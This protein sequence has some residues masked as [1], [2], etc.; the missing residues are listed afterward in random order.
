MVNSV[1]CS[2]RRRDDKK[3][4]IDPFFFSRENAL[5]FGVVPPQLPEL[6]QTEEMLIA[7]VHVHVQV[8]QYRGQQYKYR[9]HV[10]NFLRDTGSVYSQLPLLPSDLDII[11]L[12]PRNTTN[13]PHMLRQFRSQFRVRQRHI[14]TW[15]R[16]LR[17]HHPGYR[18]IAVDEDRLSQL[19]EDANIT[20]QLLTENVE[21]VN[22]EDNVADEDL[23]DA[24][25]Y[26]GAA[27]PNFIAA[28]ADLEQL[29]CQL[30]GHLAQNPE[31]VP[32]RPYLEMPAIRSTPISE[33]NR[34]QPLLSLAFPTLYPNGEA[35]FITPRQRTIKYNEYIEHAMKWHDGRFARHPR[36]RYV[37]F[38]TLMRQQVNQR[39]SFFVRRSGAG[40]RQPVDANELREAFNDDTPESR[41]L[42]NSI[43]R[44]SG[45][46]RGTRAFWNGRR[47]QL[48][49]YVHG[50]GCPGT[51]LTFSAADLHWD[52]LQRLMP[53]YHEWQQADHRSRMTIARVNLRDNP[54]IAAYHFHV[55]YTSFLEKVLKPKFNIDDYWYRYEWQARGSTHAHGLFWVK[56]SPPTPLETPEAIQ[57]FINFWTDFA[58]AFNPEPQRPVP[59]G[60]TDPLVSVSE[61]PSFQLLSDIVNRVQNHR[62]TEAYCLRRRRLNNGQ[63]SEERFCR[64]Y[65]PRFLHDEAIVTQRFNPQHQIYDGERNDPN[66]NNYNRLIALAWLANHDFSP[67]T[68]LW[69][70]LAYLAKYTAKAETKTQSYKAVVEEILPRLGSNRP[71]V[72][73]VARFMNKLASER[74]W[75]AME[76]CHLLLNLP[77]Q[78]GSR[79][80]RTVDCR[81]V[82]RQQ[83]RSTMIEDDG[84]VR[85]TRSAY[86][87]YL[88]RDVEWEGLTYFAF[89]TTIDYSRQAWRPFP[90]AKPRVLNYFPRYKPD[91]DSMDYE[92]FCRVK[93]LLHHPHRDPN[94]LKTVED[95]VFDTFTE[96][97]DYCRLVH[98]GA[99][100]HDYYGDLPLPPAAD[101]EEE[102]HNED[103]IAAEDW[104]ELAQQLPQRELDTE[105]IDILGNRDLDLRH[106]WSGHIGRY[107][108][109]LEVGREYWNKAK[110]E[111]TADD[112]LEV[113]DSV[114]DSLN[115]EQRLVF[116][117]FSRH[118][119][120]MLDPTVPNPPQLLLQVDG[121]GGTGKSFMIHAITSRLQQ[122]SPGESI[123]AKAAPTGVAANA[124]NGVTLHSLLRLPISKNLT[125]LPPLTPTEL[126]NLQAKL[127]AIR[128][129]IIDEKSM[130]GLRMLSYIDSRLRQI[131][132]SHQ[133]QFFGGRSIMLLGDFYQLPPVMEKPLYMDENLKS[134]LD[135][136]GRNAYLQ[137]NKTVVLRQVVRQQ[138][139]DQAAFRLALKGLRNNKPEV[140]HWRQL[141]SRLQS[142]LSFQEVS[143][144]D[145]A[146][147]IYP[148]NAQVKEY[149]LEHIDRLQL[150]CIQ[151]AATNVGP[152]AEE[153]D[154]T[155]AG[156]LHNKL[157][158]CIGTRVML[159]E[160]LWTATGLVNGALGSVFDISWRAD[161]TDPRKEHP[162]VILVKLDKY[163]GPAFFED[164]HLSTVVPIF[165]SNR[166]FIKVNTSC[167]R[168]QFALTVAYSITVHKS[169]GM[170]LERAVAD[171][172]QR[173]FQHGLSYVA[174]SRV[175]RLDGI[176]FDAAFDLPAI[177]TQAD[178]GI[179]ARIR[180]KD[181]RESQT[182]FPR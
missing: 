105:D 156:N 30:D 114:F 36:F 6:S 123:V 93:L 44:Y 29:R 129:I 4:P 77:L 108:E 157:P 86:D 1:C 50:L 34:S 60:D 75:S 113:P 140:N 152:K 9:G 115:A 38:N 133:D 163:T 21:E 18:D 63:L 178:G 166:D 5:H 16:Y 53:R 179:R 83:S 131:F 101:F 71:L 84:T 162:Y 146:V 91:R 37:V 118:L 103:N 143:S 102:P 120:E 145:D 180:D 181:R 26:D 81:P 64:F 122:L 88:H 150:P 87:K 58:I 54:H 43:V 151:V 76:I 90:H 56:D 66:L 35:D 67:C 175:K 96:A 11:I 2:C 132:P 136:K 148:T 14:R 80:T 33:F 173:D 128:Y 116:D 158:L 23:P 176:M 39:S 170:T 130:I 41:A 168:T 139:D 125:E 100:E 104:T 174:V 3:G 55:R 24:D 153:A 126:S 72:S 141:C 161:V 159:T 172:S 160:N 121:Q 59:R 97:Y 127:R 68:S 149:N 154:S 78:E 182:I 95:T 27:V 31:Q 110:E 10:I 51:F 142:A 135:L 19:P 82:D 45:S 65:F 40:P 46:L 20:D 144:F 147:R 109:L 70:V 79:V 106:D 177:T 69:A 74:D 8:F 32:L 99:H 73:L 48:E 47:Q 15:L 137:F 164:P 92:D 155:M 169:Q 25:D 22:I 98:Q 117:L 89:M 94:C 57:A 124:I 119:E 62:C 17:A 107:P 13:Q 61:F 167:S 42:L 111:F 28:Q 112:A 138:G 12:R 85:A 134:A 52:S 171:I 165:R 49:A 7:R